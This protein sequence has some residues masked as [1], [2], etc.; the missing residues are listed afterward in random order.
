MSSSNV[1]RARWPIAVAMVP[2]AAAGAK[3]CAPE[4]SSHSAISEASAAASPAC[5]EITTVISSWRIRFR[6]AMPPSAR[7]RARALPPR[8]TTRSRGE[9]TVSRGRSAMSPVTRPRA[10]ESSA[11]CGRRPDQRPKV[12]SSR[13]NNAAQCRF[14]ACSSYIGVSDWV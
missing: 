11:P 8:S 4:P 14:V 6:L 7:A 12:R 1:R 9:R 2:T 10:G 3:T 5:A 13:S